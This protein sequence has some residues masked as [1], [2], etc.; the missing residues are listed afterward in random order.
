MPE[1]DSTFEIDVP[2]NGFSQL[3]AQAFALSEAVRV[4]YDLT[5]EEF[6]VCA[7]NNGYKLSGSIEYTDELVSED[8]NPSV[9]TFGYNIQL[10]LDKEAAESPD[11]KKLVGKKASSPF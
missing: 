1:F 6:I 8:D 7:I 4:R 10:L 5:V 11:R 9:S 3:R 2:Y